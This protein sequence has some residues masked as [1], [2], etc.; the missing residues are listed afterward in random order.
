MDRNEKAKIKKAGK[1][2]MVYKIL[3]ALAIVLPITNLAYALY[4]NHKIN[5][6]SYSLPEQAYHIDSTEQELI[7]DGLMEWPHR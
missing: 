6:T 4:V 1:L 3:L 2:L 7:D 5:D